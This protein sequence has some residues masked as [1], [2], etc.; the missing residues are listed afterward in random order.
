MDKEGQEIASHLVLAVMLEMHKV[1]QEE[2]TTRKKGM[3][4]QMQPPRVEV[5]LVGPAV[6]E[7]A[8]LVLELKGEKVEMVCSPV[9][10]E[11]EVVV[12]EVIALDI[13]LLVVLVGPAVMVLYIF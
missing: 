5:V 7:V 9:V 13:P 12:P 2:L 6:E 11:E 10:V 1:V 8:P 3:L 4:V